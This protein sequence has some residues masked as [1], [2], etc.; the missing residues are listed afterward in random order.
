MLVLTR[1][2]DETIT[3]GEDIEVMVVAISGGKVRLGIKA[4]R[5]IE[6]H[7]LE[8]RERLQRERQGDEFARIS[9]SAKSDPLG[10]M[11]AAQNLLEEHLDLREIR[12]RQPTRTENERLRQLK[13]EHDDLWALHERLSTRWGVYARGGLIVKRTARARYLCP[14]RTAQVGS[15]C[16]LRALVRLEE[17]VAALRKGALVIVRLPRGRTKL[18]EQARQLRPLQFVELAH[19]T[20]TPA[21]FDTPTELDV[22]E[23]RPARNPAPLA[24]A[25]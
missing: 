18:S 4:P 24:I 16:Y 1:K 6:V 2:P 11:V 13:S 12:F 22:F 9:A 20:G 23:I 7:R 21:A 17:P 3:I 8:I 5:K 25:A 15:A 19:L 14:A 10:A